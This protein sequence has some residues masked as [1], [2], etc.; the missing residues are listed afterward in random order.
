MTNVT[1]IPIDT[2]LPR[3]SPEAYVEAMVKRAGTSFFWGMRRLGV[4][5]RKGVFA[6]Y[7]FCREVDDIADGDLPLE[8]KIQL[9]EA[10]RDEVG[11]IFEGEVTHPISRCIVSAREYFDLDRQDFIDVIDGMEMDAHPAVR[12]QDKDELYL[13][14]DRVAC[15]VGRLCVPVFG[16]GR[17]EGIELSKSLGMALQLTNILRD[18]CE[19]A[20]RNRVYLP[21][22]ML[23]AAGA[24]GESVS[25]I[26][27]APEL[28]SVCEELAARAGAFFDQARTIAANA[29]PDA[30]RPAVMMMEVYHRVYL[31]LLAR[32]W[33]N[34]DE[35]V[36]LSKFGKILI[37]LRYG[38]LR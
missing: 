5:R 11:R 18:I 31:R 19:D 17:Q 36:G 27:S 6:V 28:P 13:Y 1:S 33:K 23:R 26:I 24:E 14:C 4:T 9:L 16:L 25:E 38:L 12:I 37:A 2:T 15:A 32:G 3:S 22:D 35:D 21:A 8:Q 7:A 30:V 29:D 34:L 20:A 10:W